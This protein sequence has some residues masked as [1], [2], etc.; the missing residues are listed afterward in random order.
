MLFANVNASA[1]LRFLWALG[2]LSEGIWA[3]GDSEGTRALKRLLYWNGTSG[4]RGTGALK[5]LYLAKFI[6]SIKQLIPS[7]FKILLKDYSNLFLYI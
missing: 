7:C 1:S 4:T 6:Q 5:K 2:G 3:F